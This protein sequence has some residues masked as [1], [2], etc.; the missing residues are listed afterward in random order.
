MF[1]QFEN[2]KEY[3][4]WA[5]AEFL[6]KGDKINSNAIGNAL[7]HAQ[8]CAELVWRDDDHPPATERDLYV[9]FAIVRIL[10]ELQMHNSNAVGNALGLAQQ[11]ADLIFGQNKSAQGGIPSLPMKQPP[12]IATST[13]V[14]Q[15]KAPPV[16]G[17]TT[18]VPQP[19][20][21]PVNGQ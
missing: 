2:R 5:L 8:K 10:S 21:P 19:E 14:M 1:I 6:A 18:K 20:I 16:P 17:E 3:V 11:A 9:A 4:A 7:A 13:T 12:T 15:G